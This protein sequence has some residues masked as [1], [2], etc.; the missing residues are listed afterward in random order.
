MTT[1]GMVFEC[2]PQ[3]ADK[4][5]CDFLARHIRND[6]DFAFVTLDNKGNLLREAGAAVKHLLEDGCCCVLVIWDLRPAW[7]TLKRPCRANEVA[8]VKKSL[9]EAGISA[10]DPVHLICIEQELESWL[11]AN[12]QA[13]SALLSTDAHKY[14]VN[15]VKRPD[16]VTQPKSAM[17]EHFRNARS[18]RYNDTVDAMR[19]LRAAPV[20]LA[21]L[22][23][24]VSFA[25][26]EKKLL[27]C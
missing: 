7:P 20:D 8:A 5:V 14:R 19:V 26:F 12:E 1:I 9:D 25:R 4:L 11:L 16:N 23:R 10:Q 15:R 18:W 6:V 17:I 21:R 24:S 13:V 3:G 27:S 2:G 22:R